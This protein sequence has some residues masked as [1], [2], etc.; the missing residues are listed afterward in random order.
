VRPHVVYEPDERQLIEQ[1]RRAQLDTIEDV[2]DALEIRAA[3]PPDDP[4]DPVA[5]LEEQFR[6]V[7]SVLP[8]DTGDDRSFLHVEIRE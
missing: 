6:Q 3:R 5:L 4:D 7:G 1:I 2:L 8:G